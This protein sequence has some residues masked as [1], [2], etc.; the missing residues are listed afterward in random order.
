MVIAGRNPSHKRFK[1]KLAMIMIMMVVAMIIF[2]IYDE[3]VNNCDYWC[4][5]L[6]GPATALVKSVDCSFP[7]DTLAPFLYFGMTR[8]CWWW[9]Y[10]RCWWWWREYRSWW[11]HRRQAKCATLDPPGDWACQKCLSHYGPAKYPSGTLRRWGDE[12]DDENVS[13]EQQLQ[14]HLSP[15]RPRGCSCILLVFS[16]NSLSAW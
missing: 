6:E 5:G 4:S 16:I 10:R 8:W 15:S 9:L 13:G 14:C 12:R 2:I 1:V 3:D 7:P 11:R